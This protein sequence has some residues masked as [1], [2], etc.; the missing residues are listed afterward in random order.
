MGGAAGRAPAG[1]L[2]GAPDMGGAPG[3]APAGAPGG[4]VP[5]GRAVVP[6][7]FS[8]RCS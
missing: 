8:W 2:G 4:V 1:A 6:L 7:M 3:R 5:R